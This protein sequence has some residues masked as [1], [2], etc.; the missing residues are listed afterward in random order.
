MGILYPA[1][2]IA[3]AFAV[4]ALL[5]RHALEMRSK[6][7]YREMWGATS[8]ALLPAAILW[9]IVVSGESSM[10]TRTI[11]LIPAG[12]IVGGCIFAW[13]GYVIHDMTAKAQSPNDPKGGVLNMGQSIGRGSV[14]VG[15]VKANVGDDSVVVGAT[16]NNGNVRF[17]KPTTI[18]N[19]A[20]GGPDSVVI[21]NDAGGGTKKRD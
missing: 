9:L 17:D 6:Q 1:L 12:A 21:G 4:F 8:L 20:Q 16:D 19:R 2:P 11:L 7:N 13:A 14:V 3:A 5:A 10:A 15:D 18:G